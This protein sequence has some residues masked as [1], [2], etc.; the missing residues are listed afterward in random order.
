VNVQLE[1]VP[2]APQLYRVMA[3]LM[4]SLFVA[5]MDA[6]IVGTALPTIARDLGSFE[7]YPRV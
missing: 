4:V 3:R 2:W 1:R 6:T 7:L 5:A